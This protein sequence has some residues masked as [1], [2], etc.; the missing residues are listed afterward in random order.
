M[1]LF[2]KTMDLWQEQNKDAKP[3][4]ASYT[5]THKKQAI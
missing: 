4:R 5:L 1:G 3:K 2:I